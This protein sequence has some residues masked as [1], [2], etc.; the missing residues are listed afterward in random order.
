MPASERKN[1]A[2]RSLIVL[3]EVLKGGSLV[4]P[5]IAGLHGAQSLLDDEE[6]MDEHM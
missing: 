2:V 6:E 1:R 4:I 3:R 5:E